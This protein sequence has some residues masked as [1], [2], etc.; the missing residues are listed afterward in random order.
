MHIMLGE[1]LACMWALLFKLLNE[2]FQLK[3]FRK[4]SV[5]HEQF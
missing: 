3:K 1:D 5:T 4:S 2:L